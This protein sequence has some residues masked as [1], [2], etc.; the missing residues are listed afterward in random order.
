[1]GSGVIRLT[2]GELLELLRSIPAGQSVDYLGKSCRDPVTGEFV[3]WPAPRL[4]E[5]EE[6]PFEP[7]GNWLVSKAAA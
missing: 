5:L 7:D 3:G 2:D 1:M 4:S 6:S